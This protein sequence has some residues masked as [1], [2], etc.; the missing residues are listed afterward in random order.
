MTMSRTPVE[1]RTVNWPAWR[2]MGDDGGVRYGLFGLIVAGVVFRAVFG[3]LGVHDGD[4]V[5]GDAKA[6]EQYAQHLRNGDGYVLTEPLGNGRPSATHPPVFGGVLAAFSAVGLDTPQQHRLALAVLGGLGVA[7]IG[8]L[9]REL[10]G[11]AVGIVAAAIAAFHPLWM[12]PGRALY[13]ESVYLIVVPAVLLLALRAV[14][15]PTFGRF[16]VLGI[17]TGVATLTRS[18]ALLLAVFVGL[19]AV[20]L[21]APGRRLRCAAALATGTVVVVAPWV[22]RNA[23][24]LDG[25]ALSTNTG[26]TL[27]GAYCDEMFRPGPRFGSWSVGCTFRE[28]IAINR[29]VGP[30][31]PVAS[32]RRFVR[33]AIDLAREHARQVPNLMGAHIGRLW[34]FYHS[35]DQVSFED[36]TVHSHGWVV[37]G[38]YVHWVLLTFMVL[39]IACACRREWL[40]I[41]GPVLM[42]MVTAAVFYGSTRL[43]AAAEPSLALFAAAGIVWLAR[44][45]RKGPSNTKGEE[46]NARTLESDI[47]MPRPR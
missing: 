32:D 45:T 26:V 15:G 6:F 27:V 14:R 36:R 22:V 29:K 12:L 16:V 30:E 38:Q 18:E 11:A 13:S 20:L 4:Q 39:G 46:A 41:A 2:R 37:A 17:A 8:L 28:L 35:G 42:V 25:P 21:A 9:G 44:R 3:V 24:Q 47:K 5:Y 40:L 10:A 1:S 33:H 23:V 43:R 19:P 34:G 7:L 31:P